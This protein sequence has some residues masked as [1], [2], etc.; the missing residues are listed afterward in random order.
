MNILVTGGAGF[1]GSNFIRHILKKYPDFS[2]T[3]L[4]KLTY[5]G[6][7]N[8]LKD[9]EGNANYKFIKGDIADKRT[10]FKILR[11]NKIDA[12]INYAAETHVDRSI[13]DPDAFVRTDVIGTYNLLEG[14][15]EFKIAKFIQIS[16][17]EVYGSIDKGKFTE[18][19]PLLPNSPYSSSKAAGDLLCRSYVKTYGL[20][21]VITRSCNCYGP[22]QYP[23]KLISLFITNLLEDKKIPLYGRG[24]NVRE[25]L[26]VADH[27]NAVD[28]IL[29]KGEA[30]EIYNIGS[31]VEKKNSE[32]T[33]LILEQLDKGSE[34]IEYIKDR[35][36]HDLRYALNARKLEKLGWQTEFDFERAIKETVRWY[37]QNDWWWRPLKSGEYLEYYKKQYKIAL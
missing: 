29:H 33:G 7:L 20:P 30:G 3:N 12:V 9:L 31:G 34:M 11:F 18:E 13:L 22:F 25:W 32:I 35:P 26:Y 27:C 37:K 24:L 10:V 23:E 14:V 15:K 5:A 19:S 2:V 6:N 4:D 17:D 21:V 36:G 28:F 1:I 8:N 16:T